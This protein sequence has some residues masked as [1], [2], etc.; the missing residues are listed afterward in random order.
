MGRE[1]TA[2][3][4]ELFERIEGWPEEAQEA[5]VRVLQKL[6]EEFDPPLSQ[7]DIAAIERG[8]E[9]VRQGRTYSWEEVRTAFDKHGR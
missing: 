1:T 8:L 6:D 2:A 7:D 3:L 4:K 5:V 9:D